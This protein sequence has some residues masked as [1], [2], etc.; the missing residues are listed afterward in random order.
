MCVCVLLVLP[1]AQPFAAFV[2]ASVCVLRIALL[3]TLPTLSVPPTMMRGE[4]NNNK[5]T[6]RKDVRAVVAGDVPSASHD[7][8]HGVRVSRHGRD[9]RS[10]CNVPSV[11]T[12][13]LPILAATARA[14]RPLVGSNRKQNSQ[15]ASAM[16]CRRRVGA[17]VY[18]LAL[19]HAADSVD[20]CGGRLRVCPSAPA[21]VSSSGAPST[22]CPRRPLRVLVRAVDL[23]ASRRPS[24]TTR[25][26]ATASS[27]PNQ[28]STTS[29]TTVSRRRSRPSETCTRSCT[30]FATSCSAD[31]W[32]L[33]R[34]TKRTR[35]SRGAPAAVVVVA[36]DGG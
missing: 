17:C 28:G 26:C 35:T 1:C 7:D 23:T 3:S 21:D 19:L 9:V 2:C 14:A 34:R 10:V 12:V 6:D 32:S 24:T 29:T 25:P 5:I 18:M 15:V 31:P 27:C 36:A 22:F 30:T 13:P 33:W 4:R 16:C 20:G 8:V 11:P